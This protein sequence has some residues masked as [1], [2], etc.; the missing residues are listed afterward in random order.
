MIA[1]IFGILSFSS[2]IRDKKIIKKPTGKSLFFRS[3]GGLPEIYSSPS[4]VA[5]ICMSHQHPVWISKYDYLSNTTLLTDIFFSSERCDAFLAYSIRTDVV[6]A[7]NH[8]NQ[9]FPV[10]VRSMW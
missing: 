2:G 10:R 5:V 4:C 7:D 8:S 9:F 3:E 6:Y 1:V